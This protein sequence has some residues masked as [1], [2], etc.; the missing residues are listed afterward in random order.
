MFWMAIF[1]SYSSLYVC[2][3]ITDISNKLILFLLF[4]T[5]STRM[6]NIISEK[7]RYEKPTTNTKNWKKLRYRHFNNSIFLNSLCL[8]SHFIH[9]FSW[10]FAYFEQ[11]S[12]A[13]FQQLK[14]EQKTILS[15]IWNWVALTNIFNDNYLSSKPSTISAE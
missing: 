9:H 13:T 2:E 14:S 15:H 5:R 8:F 3:R 10:R 6:K 11:R 12:M 1:F 4:F 7:K